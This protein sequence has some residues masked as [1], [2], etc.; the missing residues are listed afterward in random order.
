V[1]GKS[2]RYSG[3][4][5][6]LMLA[7]YSV[8]EYLT[9]NRVQKEMKSPYWLNA[10]MATPLIAEVCLTYLAFDDLYNSESHSRMTWET[11]MQLMEDY[12]F[13]DYAAFYWGHHVLL[14]TDDEERKRFETIAADLLWDEGSIFRMWVSIFDPSRNPS[15]RGANYKRAGS[16]L[17]YFSLLGLNT[18]VELSISRGADVN[19]QGGEYVTALTAAAHHGHEKIVRLMLANGANVNAQG[20]SYLGTYCCT[21]LQEAI[22]EGH[23]NIARRLIE[24][25][26]DVNAKDCNKHGTALRIAAYNENKDIV[27]LL[28]KKGANVNAS[29]QSGT[30]LAAASRKGNLDL[31]RLM[32]KHGA[33]IE[34]T[35]TN[36]NQLSAIAAAALSGNE[37]VVD[38]LI[39]EGG[40]VNAMNTQVGDNEEP[41]LCTALYAVSSLYPAGIGHAV[42]S[43]YPA[44]ID[45]A[46]E[47][48]RERAMQLLRKHG[49]EM[50]PECDKPRKL[51]ADMRSWLVIR[52]TPA[53][54]VGWGPGF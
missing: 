22:K 17:Y 40:D 52:I 29:T 11:K 42:P 21:A 50:K 32:L 13:L 4:V 39:A 9:S 1:Y 31:V 28:L 7:H 19:T 34:V 12:P 35:P 24:N 41:S 16:A 20:R 38:L 27:Q 36:Q 25:G 48:V 30:A 2:S 6:Q 10:Q 37:A 15:R 14:I 45:E 43:L 3:H 8:K 26:A 47:A 49:A 23:N 54:Y 5:V 33:Q 46:C 18:A 53:P 44:G 51:L